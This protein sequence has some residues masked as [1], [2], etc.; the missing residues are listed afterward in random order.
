VF[1]IFGYATFGLAMLPWAFRGDIEHLE[2][3]KT[4]PVTPLAVTA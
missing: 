4:L 2:V 3:L 1:V